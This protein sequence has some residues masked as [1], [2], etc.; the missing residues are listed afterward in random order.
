MGPRTGLDHS[1]PADIPYNPPYKDKGLKSRVFYGRPL[2]PLPGLCGS[3]NFDEA[4]EH[5]EDAE[6]ER[7]RSLSPHA[8]PT[9]PASSA[10]SKEVS[11]SSARRKKL[12]KKT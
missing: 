5:E 4:S 6:E 9:R 1:P 12:P 11:V 10:S 8:D 7:T 2:L 3:M